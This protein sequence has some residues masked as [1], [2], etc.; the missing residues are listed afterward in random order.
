MILT[1]RIRRKARHR[2]VRKRIFGTVER[3]RLCVFRSGKHFCAQTIDDYGGKTLFS[4]STFSKKFQ[5]TQAKSA[6]VEGARKL[7]ELF[8]PEM[9]AKKIKKVVFDRGGHQYHGRVKAF[10]EALREAGV[11]F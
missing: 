5:K 1:P 7:G 10:A 2:R 11:E 9:I 4:F 6:T 3:P 8:G